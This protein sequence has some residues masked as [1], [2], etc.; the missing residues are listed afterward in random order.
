MPTTNHHIWKHN[1]WEYWKYHRLP[2]GTL[3]S[4]IFFQILI[5]NLLSTNEIFKIAFADDVTFL[6]TIDPR[7]F[8]DSI[9]TIN[10]M[11]Q[12]IYDWFKLFRIGVNL[13]KEHWL[14]NIRI[15]SQIYLF[16]L[17]STAYQ[18]KLYLISDVLESQLMRNYLSNNI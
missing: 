2:Q 14:Y 17:W 8:I 11:L 1:I 9:N 5:N 15:K 4:P 3:L 7:N 12:H 6:V 16:R 13:G 10:Q 18:L